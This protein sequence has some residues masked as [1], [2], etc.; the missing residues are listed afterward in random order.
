MKKI[1]LILSSLLI[2]VLINA[3]SVEW[4]KHGKAPKAE[5]GNGI[6]HD[7][8]GNIYITGTFQDSVRFDNILLTTSYGDY[9][10]KYDTLG[11]VIWAK[12]GIGGN[13][14]M[15]DGNNS[16]Y[17]YSKTGKT[18]KKLDLSGNTTWSK[19][20]YTTSSFGSDGIMGVFTK[21]NDVYVTGYFSYDAYFDNDTLINKGSWDAYIAKFDG[22]GQNIWATAIGG[23]GTDKG[24][25]IYVNGLDEIYA[26]GYYK[27][28]A[29]FDNTQMI[30]NGNTDAYLAKY[31]NNANLIW[32]NSYG[33]SNLDLAACI[34]VDENENIYTTGRYDGNITFGSTTLTS[35]GSDAFVAKFDDAGNPIWA[36][37]I[38]GTSNDEEGDLD[39]NNGELAFISTTLGDV[40]I[41]G[42]LFSGKGYLDICLGVFDVSGNLTWAKFYG[43]TAADEGSGVTLI[44]GSVYFTGSF[45]N[46]VDFDNFQLT[47][48]GNWDIVTGKISP[49]L[50]TGVSS[51][52]NLVNSSNIIYPNPT[53]GI[54]FIEVSDFTSSFAEIINLEGKL[55]DKIKLNNNKT[56]LDIKSLPAGIY[57]L[58]VKTDKAIT[59]K[60]IVKQN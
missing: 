46:T 50:T 47:S 6:T 28:T 35:V 44:N 59:T 60:K 5:Q 23:N 37:G 2:S 15:F 51:F 3:Q 10:A 57:F 7:N 31:D 12:K 27:D 40:T 48:L 26:V 52:T 11:N 38:S 19:T 43:N 42:N 56:V 16:L 33:S 41:D 8:Y 58:R 14:I 45:N 1:N 18:L 22:N 25:D 30:S 36:Q 24:Y 17:A 39:Y 49:Q 9:C 55:I 32:V 29:Y 20:L 4:V 13:G 34:V 21:N 54:L 53:K